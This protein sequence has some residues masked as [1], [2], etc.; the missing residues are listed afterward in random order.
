MYS[1]YQM[2]K[3]P[4]PGRHQKYNRQIIANRKGNKRF[5]K[6]HAHLAMID[7]LFIRPWCPTQHGCFEPPD[8][9]PNF[10]PSLLTTLQTCGKAL[11]GP[12]ANPTTKESGHPKMDEGVSEELGD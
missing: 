5:A 10:F 2:H 8:M 7:L 6:Y 1:I 9:P 4:D 11:T 3:L 12:S